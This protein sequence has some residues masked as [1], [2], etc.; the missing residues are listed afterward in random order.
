MLPELLAA[1]MR[2]FA[3]SSRFVDFVDLDGEAQG[4]RFEV[5]SPSAHFFLSFPRASGDDPTGDGN[6]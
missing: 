5:C 4:S 1:W 6:R 3:F 2:Q